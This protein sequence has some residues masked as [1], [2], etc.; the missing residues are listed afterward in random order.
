V[1]CISSLSLLR[2]LFSDRPTASGSAEGFPIRAL[3]T[4][5]ALQQLHDAV[6]VVLLIAAAVRVPNVPLAATRIILRAAIATTGPPELPSEPPTAS[7]AVW[8]QMDQRGRK[9]WSGGIDAEPAGASGRNATPMDR[10]GDKVVGVF[11]AEV[12]RPEAC[13]RLRYFLDSLPIRT[14]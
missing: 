11:G 10:A 8:V 6:S 14:E 13:A 5:D 9:R 2:V 3:C 1:P 7:S 12:A 4:A